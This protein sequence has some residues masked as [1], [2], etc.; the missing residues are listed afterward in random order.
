MLIAEGTMHKG[1]LVHHVR[2]GH[3]LE[4]CRII[5]GVIGLKVR[6]VISRVRPRV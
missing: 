4:L 3:K 1:M 6:E 2:L 5:I